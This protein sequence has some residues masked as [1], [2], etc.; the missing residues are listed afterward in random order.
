[1]QASTKAEICSELGIKVI[2]E[3]SGE[4]AIECAQKNIS[5]IL[6]DKPWNKIHKHKKIVRVKEWQ[7]A[8]R[9]LSSIIKKS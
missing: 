8:M 1:M 3:D 9:A 6:F 5:V 4:T 2:L 7:E